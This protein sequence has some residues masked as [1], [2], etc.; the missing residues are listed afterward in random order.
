VFVVA[1][2]ELGTSVDDET[3][4]LAGD[5]GTTVYEA[6][7][8]LA[9]GIPCVILS[10]PDRE[11]AL[12]L[13]GKLR[14]R[15]HGAVAFDGHAVVPASSMVA[16]RQYRLEHDA[17]EL[18]PSDGAPPSNARL[19]FAEMT[20]LLR[21]MHRSSHVRREDVKEVKFRAGA[22]IATGGLIMTKTVKKQVRTT[23]EERE[24]VLYVFGKVGAPWLLRESTA[25][26]AG[27]G[28]AMHPTRAMNFAASV[29]M[30]RERAPNAAYDERLLA[31]KRFPEPAKDP[32]DARGS[33]LATGGVDLLAHVLGLWLTRKSAA[34]D[35]L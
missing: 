35:G 6:R 28:E 16:V 26:Y 24:H 31:V 7:L 10:T 3:P 18:D 12:A 4:A 2:A 32:G 9:A 29:R 11:R 20:A 19:P 27:L 17:L 25:Q 1:I 22:A 5:L 23:I 33:D 34:K 8:R 14:A 13:L 21:A 15:G 30:I